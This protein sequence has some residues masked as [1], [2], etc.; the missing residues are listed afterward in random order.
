MRR[1][2][3]RAGGSRR[4]RPVHSFRF[5]ENRERSV[6]RQ[7]Q[8]VGFGGSDGSEGSAELL[9]HQNTDC[10]FEGQLLKIFFINFFF[11]LA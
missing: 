1:L 5:E 4:A 11:A 3:A 9:V 10:E 7:D 8:S 6:R 2:P